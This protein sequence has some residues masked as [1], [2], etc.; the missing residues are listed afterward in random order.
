MSEDEPERKPDT[1][2]RDESTASK[3]SDGHPMFMRRVNPL[4]EEKEDKEARRER[5]LRSIRALPSANPKARDMQ[6]DVQKVTVEKTE[7]GKPMDK[8]LKMTLI[9]CMT[10]IVVALIM[11]PSRYRIS[12]NSPHL[13][14]DSSSGNVWRL[15][16]GT[17]GTSPSYVRIDRE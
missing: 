13:L 1:I 12:D 15:M 16:L 11:R 17:S 4:D 2:A 7:E 3:S 14:L 10:V 6:A 9:V 8:H 5:I